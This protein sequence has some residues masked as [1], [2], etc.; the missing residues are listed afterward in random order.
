[1]RSGSAAG[2][3]QLIMLELELFINTKR[4]DL[5]CGHN[6]VAAVTDGG[7]RCVKEHPSRVTRTLKT[8]TG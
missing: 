1:M 5:K 8:F 3:L 2:K 4:S 7:G 6:S